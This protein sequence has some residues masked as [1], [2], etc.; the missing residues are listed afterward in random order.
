MK[1]GVW[2]LMDGEYNAT[3]IIS[4]LFAFQG[5]GPM[6]LI[7]H[8]SLTVEASLTVLPLTLHRTFSRSNRDVTRRLGV[9]LR[10]HHATSLITSC[11]TAVCS[12]T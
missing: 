5:T 7:S 4:G 9:C 2:K 6:R 12:S 10:R 3:I 11:R 8:L 1:R